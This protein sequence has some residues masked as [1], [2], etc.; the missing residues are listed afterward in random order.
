MFGGTFHVFNYEWRK[1][2]FQFREPTSELPFALE[3]DRVRT[4]THN[5]CCTPVRG[6]SIPGLHYYDTCIA[7]SLFEYSVNL[8]WSDVFQGGAGPIQMVVQARVIKHLMFMHHSGS[9]RRTLHR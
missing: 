9:D 1:S 7:K 4:G 3:T 5:T 2:F 8:T 6:T